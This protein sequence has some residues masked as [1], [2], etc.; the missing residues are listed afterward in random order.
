MTPRQFIHPQYAA[1]LSRLGLDSVAGA[2]GYAGGQLLTKPGL[3]VRE[4]LRLKVEGPAGEQV[5]Y[6]KRYS[7]GT[8]LRA[9]LRRESPAW[10]ELRNILL[11]QQAGVPTMQCLAAGQADGRGYVIVT[12]VPGESLE[13][14]FSDFW[15]RHHAEPA[16]LAAFD[17]ALLEL[18]ARLH[19]AGLVHRDLYASH[20]FAEW[21]DR[22]VLHLIDLA[23][24][25]RPRWR[26]FRWRVKDMA[27]LTYSL[28]PEWVAGHWATFLTRYVARLGQQDARPWT[29]AVSAKLAWMQ[30]R[31]SRKGESSRR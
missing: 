3:G 18:V 22:P 27:A 21:Q 12:A 15:Q 8:G 1:M 19:G 6:L 29:R 5:L 30:R 4:R 7:R 11:C 24:V 26:A 16:A 9:L 14:C 28:P 10:R 25:F 17:D 2:F 20:I 31:L 23:R 13:T